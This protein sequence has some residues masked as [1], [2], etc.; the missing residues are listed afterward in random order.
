MPD[1]GAVNAVAL[2]A[3]APWIAEARR[4]ERAGDLAGAIEAL[5]RGV[6]AQPQN[7]VLL[8]RLAVRLRGAG[9]FFDSIAVMRRA[10]VA[11]PDGRMVLLELGTSLRLD[12]RAEEALRLHEAL[13]RRYPDDLEAVSAWALDIALTGDPDRGLDRALA[14]VAANR[15]RLDLS[16]VLARVL[17]ALGRHREAIQRVREVLARVPRAYS[18]W[19]VLGVAARG[20]G[21]DAEL[22]EAATNAAKLNERLA[23]SQHLLGESAER[24]GDPDEARWWYREALS[25]HARFYLSSLALGRLHGRAGEVEAARERLREAAALGA[26]DGRARGTWLRFRVA[27]GDPGIALDKAEVDAARH[28]YSGLALQIG[29]IYLDHRQDPA[30]AVSWL[31]R[32]AEHAPDD[33]RAWRWYAQAATKAGRADE[34]GRAERHLAALAS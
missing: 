10:Q 1:A 15:N 7:P 21:R 20:A 3:A 34:A 32:A 6:T 12:F 29:R 2:N 4:A 24:R 5:Q 23:W 22:S 8:T 11:A 33:P 18:G 16:I 14:L 9:R 26:W 17:V 19:T 25:T 13:A 27:V 28:P 30:G 31:R